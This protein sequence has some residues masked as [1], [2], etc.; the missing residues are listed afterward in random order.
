MASRASRQDDDRPRKTKKSKSPR[1]ARLCLIIGIVVVVLAGGGWVAANQVINHYADEV[2]KSDILGGVPQN[3]RASVPPSGAPVTGPL[4]ILMLGS[5][6]A[7]GSRAKTQGVDGQRSDSIILFHIDKSFQHVYAFSIERDSYVRIPAGG[8]WQGGKD[9]INAALQYGGPSLTLRTVQDLLGI[10]INYAAVVS[11]SALIK[12]VDAVGGVDVNVDKTTYDNQFKR[13]WTKGIHH[14]TGMDAE[15]YVRQRHGLAAGDYD[16]MKRQ[17]QVIRAL[18]AKATTGGVLSNPYKLNALLETVIGSVTVET[19]TPV[20]DLVFASRSLGLGAV[21]FSTM[22]MNGTIQMG[23]TD[24]ERVSS[25]GVEAL[26]KAINS[27]DFTAYL[28]K[29]PPND[30]S[31]GL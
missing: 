19:T 13:T 8:S 12:A 27:D 4:N 31:H 22:P 28:K 10:K 25:T 14:L 2:H 1:W 5:D 26:G 23:G 15:Y 29:Y 17:Q 3:E 9:K 30:A 21:T 24:Y 18:V 11:F 16:R 20:K 7:D 6:N